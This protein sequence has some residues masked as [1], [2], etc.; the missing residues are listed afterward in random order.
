MKI[1]L[2][3][4]TFSGNASS[5]RMPSFGGWSF[6]AG[7]GRSLRATGATQRFQAWAVAEYADEARVLN[8]SK[9]T[10]GLR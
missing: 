1:H 2:L 8:S 3:Q 7:L 4:T 6:I 9:L 5:R 10:K